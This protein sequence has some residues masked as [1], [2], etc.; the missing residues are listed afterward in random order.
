LALIL[1]ALCALYFASTYSRDDFIALIT[2]TTAGVVIASAAVA[3][4]KPSYGLDAVRGDAW[5]GVFLTKNELGRVAALGVGLWTLRLFTLRGH[6]AVA[7]LMTSCCAATLAASRSR[8]GE[9]VVFV[10]LAFIVALPIIRSHWSVAIPGA[11]A[12]GAL[13]TVIGVYLTSHADSALVSVGSE[14]TLTGRAGIWSAVWHMISLKPLLGYGYGAFWRGFDGPSAYVWTTIHATPPH[15]HNGLLDAWLDL[16]FLGAAPMVA[17]VL[18]TAGRAARSARAG[19]RMESLAPA[20][21]LV[22]LV[23]YNVTESTFIVRNSFYFIVLV[24][25]AIYVGR[26]VAIPERATVPAPFG[27]TTR[28][29]ES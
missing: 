8:T 10:L 22:F 20:V 6:P 5:R 25:T 24:A 21:L 15:A 19:W 3:V 2:W 29:A 28:A 17:V 1:T 11:A 27:L 4:L 16:G 7:L 18:I 26:P 23:F 9:L 12:L 13:A 14:Q